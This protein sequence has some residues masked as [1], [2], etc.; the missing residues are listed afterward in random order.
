MTT[1]VIVKETE[2][3]SSEPDI[4]LPLKRVRSVCDRIRI[5]FNSREV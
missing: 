3:T 1:Q 4:D 2:S 5:G